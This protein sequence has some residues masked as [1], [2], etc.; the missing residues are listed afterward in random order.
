MTM[1]NDD[2]EELVEPGFA[3][4]SEYA[5]VLRVASGR[6]AACA[7]VSDG[8]TGSGIG[9]EAAPAVAWGGADD[10]DFS[11]VTG[12]VAVSDMDGMGGS[13]VPGYLLAAW[14]G[15]RLWLRYST[16]LPGGESADDE[17]DA[18]AVY[19]D[20]GAMTDGVVRL[21]AHGRG[22]SLQVVPLSER[23]SWLKRDGRWR[24]D[25]PW[26]V[27]AVYGV[28]PS[29]DLWDDGGNMRQEYRVT[30]WMVPVGRA[31]CF[32][33]TSSE[34][35]AV[36]GSLAAVSERLRW[37]EFGRMY[38]ETLWKCGPHAAFEAALLPWEAD[39]SEQW[40]GA[41]DDWCY[42]FEADAMCCGR[43]ADGAQMQ[44]RAGYARPVS[45]CG[46]F[47]DS[48]L[49]GAF[50][51]MLG[52]TVRPTIEDV[53][54]FPAAGFGEVLERGLVT[55]PLEPAGVYECAQNYRFDADSVEGLGMSYGYRAGFCVASEDVWP[56]AA[57][58]YRIT[59]RAEIATAGGSTLHLR[60]A[61][62][63]ADGVLLTASMFAE[64]LKGWTGTE[65]RPDSPGGG[66]GGGGENDF[67][68]E[69]E[70][71]KPDDGTDDDE[72]TD[73]WPGPGPR[74]NP[75][76]DEDVDEDSN[77][78]NRPAVKIGY[79]RGEGF[80]SCSLVRR[81][82]AYFWKLVLDGA[83]VSAALRNVEV[84]GSVTLKAGGS[85][86]GTTATVYMGLRKTGGAS[87]SVS[88]KNVTST[89][90]L[91]FRGDN[92]QDIERGAVK[93]EFELGFELDVDVHDKVWYLSTTELSSAGSWVRRS[94]SDGVSCFQ[95]RA[96]EWYKFSVDAAA[97]KA[98]AVNE[99]SGR[100]SRRRV[101]DSEESASYDST[102]SATL[103]G[104]VLNS[105]AS[106][107]LSGNNLNSTSSA[108]LS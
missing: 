8:L 94:V 52:W 81:G 83:A 28:H 33:A 26:E 76:D 65:P 80:K 67:T 54:G 18:A 11:R 74:P 45:V 88:G 50:M 31:V 55:A 62:T 46:R 42:G 17:A 101:S 7:T 19:G 73:D 13:L 99:L 97:L 25:V 98:A 69:D 70:K 60:L 108:I 6:L 12:W 105:T 35:Y 1:N 56:Q 75:D 47:H 89:A 90:V 57:D 66:S 95:A 29:G 63:E 58:L 16:E 20:A 64:V 96:Q 87:A 27:L 9:G 34:R 104:N 21:R 23:E 30:L 4:G 37:S 84:P 72:E 86:Q 78:E 51:A 91:A 24:V 10:A 44:R 41:E 15:G 59:L 77:P 53:F 100:L 14:W 93:C 92:M 3:E 43:V 82:G 38:G 106:A 5:G 71:W 49:L 39:G 61:G 103:S 107:T 40:T 32:M 36:N 79:E 22:P 68:P 48:S 2:F 85:Q 102:V